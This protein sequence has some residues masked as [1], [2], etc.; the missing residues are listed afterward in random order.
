M[1]SLAALAAATA[2]LAGCASHETPRSTATPV[3][4]ALS[5]GART[6]TDPD[7]AC[8]RSGAVRWVLPLTGTYRLGRPGFGSVGGT[9]AVVHVEEGDDM[10]LAASGGSVFL[11]SGEQLLAVDVATGRLRWRHVAPG[12]TGYPVDVVGGRVLYRQR[13]PYVSDGPFLS[14]DPRTGS[15]HRIPVRE[16]EYRVREVDSSLVLLRGIGTW[17]DSDHPGVRLVDPV[18]GRTRWDVRLGR[19]WEYQVRDGVLYADDFRLR[20]DVPKTSEHRSQTRA[21]QRVDLR[22]GRRLPDVRVPKKYWGDVHLDYVTDRGVIVVTTVPADG[23]VK[24]AFDLAGR[25]VT[26]VPSFSEAEEKQEATGEKVRVTGPERGI[27][28]LSGHGWT[29][30]A[31]RAAAFGTSTVVGSRPRVAVAVACAPD[32]VRPGTLEDPFP[33]TY[34]C[35]KPRFFGVTW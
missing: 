22:T 26:P 5:G 15:A 16:S 35:T 4:S 29:G 33:S 7:A 31:M 3:R 8:G 34:Y 20:R 12:T 17:R 32:A 18:S 13:T 11:Q 2:V 21:I 25:P 19:G 14:L 23:N 30:P 1:T 10:S 28:H 24:H 27:Q 6:C 9:R